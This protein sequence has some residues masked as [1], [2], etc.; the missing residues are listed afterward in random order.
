[1]TGRKK[2]CGPLHTAGNTLILI[3]L[4]VTVALACDITVGEASKTLQRDSYYVVY[5]YKAPGKDKD[6]EKAIA[7]TRERIK[8]LV[9][10]Y[11]DK[12]NLDFYASAVEKLVKDEKKMV[13]EEFKVTKFPASLVIRPGGKL[14]YKT[15][16]EITDKE[17]KTL[18]Y[19]PTKKKIA[20]AAD[21]FEAVAVCIVGKR[22]KNKDKL[23][24]NLKKSV[25]ISE[26]VIG[27]KIKIIEVDAG[28][29]KEKY[30]FKN[31]GIKPSV[32]E[33]Y[34]TLVFGRG[35][36]RRPVKGAA[37]VNVL[38]DYIQVLA[39]NCSCG[40]NWEAAGEDLLMEET[41]PP[42]IPEE[43]EEW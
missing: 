12:I 10:K 5:L 23:L 6:K 31:L 7:G 3:A 19:S 42:K 35:K 33:I 13:T 32:R 1:M 29:A 41:K 34:T 8:K 25:D 24:K 22:A 15:D 9:A 17:L 40:F 30:F 27:G 16:G 37:T 43:E 2:S 38:N 14:L 20:D 39:N 28:D 36:A 4:I 26:D 11:G 21:A 18:I